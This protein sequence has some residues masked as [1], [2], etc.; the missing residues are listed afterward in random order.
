MFST[1]F[2]ILLHLYCRLFESLQAADVQLAD[3]WLKLIV[4]EKLFHD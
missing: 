4:T 1:N 2:G 3:Q